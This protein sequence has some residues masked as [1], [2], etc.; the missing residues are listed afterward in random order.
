MKQA[1]II[2]IHKADE[3]KASK[4][5]KLAVAASHELLK[6]ARVRR[7]GLEAF[8]ESGK[9]AA[10]S[11]VPQA[12]ID[13]PDRRREEFPDAFFIIEESDMGRSPKNGKRDYE[14]TAQSILLWLKKFYAETPKPLVRSSELS[15]VVEWIEVQD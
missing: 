15:I 9:F 12:V 11:Q 5:T 13:N 14:S 8:I 3:T 4:P 1:R 10:M 2:L 6:V 7:P